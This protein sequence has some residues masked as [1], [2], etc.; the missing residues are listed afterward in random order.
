M[1]FLSDKLKASAADQIELMIISATRHLQK[2]TQS[3]IEA[4]LFEAV[5][6]YQFCMSGKLPRLDVDV[7]PPF[8]GSWLITPQAHIGNYRV[9]FLIKDS[10]TGITAVV[11]CDGHDFHERT[12]EQARKDR[13]RDRELQAKGYLVLRYTGS[14]IWRDPW[15]CA[16]DIEFK[17]YSKM[18][19]DGES[20]N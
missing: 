20:N 18:F 5:M 3:P 19:A 15:K 8:D 10:E 12:K 6:T 7:P 17:M 2:H 16:E 11:E 13:S 14:E 9:D 1:K 4:M